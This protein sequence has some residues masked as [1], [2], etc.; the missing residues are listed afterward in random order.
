MLGEDMDEWCD[1][2][3]TVPDGDR[4]YRCTK[5]GK[6]LHPRKMF[7][8]AGELEG[9]RLPPHKKKGHKIRRIKER[10]KKIRACQKPHLPQ[11][12]GTSRRPG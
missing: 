8:I 4:I 5:C 12:E 7:G 3:D 1:Q 2:Q 9:W 10:R 11:K 6:R